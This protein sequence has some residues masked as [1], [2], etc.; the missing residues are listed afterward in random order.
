MSVVQRCPTCGTTQSTAGECAACHEAQ[1]RYFCTNHE[2][3]LWL[4]GP[5]CPQ[6]EARAT[7]AARPSP[8]TPAPISTT[9]ARPARARPAALA[10]EVRAA[11]TARTPTRPVDD[12]AL[13]VRPSR[14]ALW[15]QLFRGAML[16]RPAPPAEED[17]EASPRAGGWLK[18]LIVRL[19]LIALVLIAALGV[20]VYFALR[21]LH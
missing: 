12:E 16:A 1:V 8:A 4:S 11:G 10:T 17:L 21:S 18:Q 19:V 7:L 5:T 2:P 15:A 20:A 13:D 9:S 3:G 6:C 14:P